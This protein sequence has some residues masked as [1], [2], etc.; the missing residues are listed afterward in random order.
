VRTRQK[1]AEAIVAQIAV[2]T[3]QERRAE[4]AG[5]C[6]Q[7]DDSDQTGEKNSETTWAWQL[8]PPPVTAQ[9]W[10][11]DGCPGLGVRGERVRG[12]AKNGSKTMHKAEP[13]EAVTLES[14][15]E[16]ENLKAAWQ[17]VKANGGAAGVDG[18][19]VEQ[20]CDY[21]RAQW[22]DI[23]QAL[24]N[25]RYTPGAVR[26]VQIPKANG[27]VRTLG[28]PTVLDRLIQ[29][30]IHQ[31]LSPQWEPG[32]SEHS[33]GFRPGRS[34]HE[35]VRAGQ[36]YVKAGKSWVI[37]IDLK[38][39]FD[40]VGHD[41][42]MHL[43]GQKVRDKGLLR[44]I[45]DYLRAPM[46]WPDG[47]QELRRQGTP[48]GG[49]LSPLLANIYL[50]PLDQELEKRGL[51]FV[52]YADDIAIF[53]SSER[54]AERVKG[55]VVAWIEKHLKLEVNREKTGSGPSDQSGLLGFRLYP[56]GR[57]GVT[58]KTVERLRT[59]VRQLWDARQS[60]TSN[61]LRTQWQRYIRGWWNYFALADWRREV[62]DQSGWIRRHMR[63]CFWLRWKTPRGR[64]NALKRL[65]VRGRAL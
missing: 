43:V 10:A 40:R 58:P 64:L 59:K 52:R 55:S 19:D 32:L 20:S 30:A 60:V 1:S 39:F 47:R 54:S 33:Y 56:D 16:K 53:V 24:L 36:R 25:G 46:L 11:R 34:A 29:Q 18:R 21:I 38:S 65:G 5:K 15:L 23:E 27:G 12:W 6:D 17:Q 7:P 44:L 42:L 2:E 45:G 8:R 35:A 31:R 37:D 22:A 41:K 57:I 51:S 49:P 4:E 9:Q 62:E 28:I 26:A 48:Q 63:K 13:M 50:D 14:V 61:Q 3:R